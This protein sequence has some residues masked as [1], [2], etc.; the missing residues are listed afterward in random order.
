MAFDTTVTDEDTPLELNQTEV[1]TD[2]TPQA[3]AETE[4]AD[5][6][7]QAEYTDGET[8]EQADAKGDS[9]GDDA[10]K[11]EGDDTDND[12][13]KPKSRASQRIKELV[14]ERNAEREA[15]ERLEQQL[16]QQGNQPPNSQNQTGEPQPPNIDDFDIETED[17]LQAYFDA[18][19]QYDK[20]VRDWELDSRL[21]EREQAREREAKEAEIVNEYKKRFEQNPKFKEDFANLQT[22]MQDKP[23]E[24]DPSELYQG[25]E[26][27][28][29]LEEVAGN[30]DL[31]YEIAELPTQAQYAKYGEIQARIKLRKTNSKG[32]GVTKAP[33]P[34]N[35]TKSNAP[36]KRSDY[37]KSDDDFL[38]ARGLG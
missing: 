32:V 12:G 15:R 7:L 2:K 37:D 38:A 22:L 24:A 36:I 23:I 35:H 29:L 34:P 31:Y 33:P 10:S 25:E 5:A 26:L 6:G 27:M 16:K 17:G 11:T 28:D 8:T 19:A 18:H 20:V 1:S 21:Q 9:N 13:D 4:Q 14:A 30:P 3:D